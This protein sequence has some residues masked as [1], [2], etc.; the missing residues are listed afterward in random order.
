MKDLG[1][2]HKFLGLE[3]WLK[4]NKV[5]LSQGKYAIYEL[6]RFGMMNCRSM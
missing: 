4:P 6:K 2:M 3:V 1:Q 5:F